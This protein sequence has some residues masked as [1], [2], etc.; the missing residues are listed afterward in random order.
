MYRDGKLTTITVIKTL[1]KTILEASTAFLFRLC[2]HVQLS[3]R[4]GPTI[5]VRALSA[6]HRH[7]TSTSPLCPSWSARCASVSAD[8]L[9]RT[10]VRLWCCRVEQSAWFTQRHCSVTVLFSE[11]PR[12]FSSVVTNTFSASKV[13]RQCRVMPKSPLYLLTYL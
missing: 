4:L 9:R 8:N 11:P 10:F 3:T 12:H 13:V 1:V 5:S 2:P 7:R 6:G